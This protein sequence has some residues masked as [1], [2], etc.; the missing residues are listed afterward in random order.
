MNPLNP[1]VLHREINLLANDIER[2]M[3]DIREQLQGVNLSQIERL[4][5]VGSGD[6]YFASMV[7]SF[8]LRSSFGLSAN[9]ITAFEFLSYPI[10]LEEHRS[11]LIVAASASGNTPRVV[12]A[13]AEARCRGATTMAVTSNPS[14]ELCK[15]LE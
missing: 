2:L 3:P 8:A 1:S 14:A 6:S 11:S 15:T 4:S 12:Q 7:T 13:L 5:F 9:A 10:Q